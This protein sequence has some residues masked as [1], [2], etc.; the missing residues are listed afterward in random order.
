LSEAPKISYFDL[1]KT[2]K[3][4]KKIA[5]GGPKKHPNFF[6][7]AAGP[8]NTTFFIAEKKSQKIPPGPQKVIFF[9]P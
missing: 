8:K 6:S 5:C 4:Q 1:Q 7:P 2:P 9:Y 3:N